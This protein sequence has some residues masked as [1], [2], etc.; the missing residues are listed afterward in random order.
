MLQ[1]NFLPESMY[2]IDSSMTYEKLCRFYNE[3]TTLTGKVRR[4]NS[5]KKI[6]EVELGNGF[7]GFM[8][9]EEATIYSLYKPDGTI[10]PNLNNLVEKTI[11]VRI[12]SLDSSTQ[13][14]FLS[15]KAHMLDAINVFKNETTIINAYIISFSKHSA[16]FDIGAGIIGRANTKNFSTTIFRNIRDIGFKVG[17]IVTVQILSFLEDC[18]K[19]DVS[20]V[21]PLPSV[22][23]ALSEGDV[24]TAKVF[25]P[26]NDVEKIGYYVLV[27]KNYKG[28]VDSP[29]LNLKYGDI[30][31]V[32]IKKIKEDGNL[33]VTLIKN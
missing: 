25:E 28:I 16:F 4:I 9:F 20:R 5:S 1:Q 29:Y 19:F 27:E 2:K 13:T 10:S 17:D 3:G 31:T 7:L 32:F 18:A 21:N 30:I 33:K 23:N 26:V 24:V 8:S 22:F 12:I 11:R 14:T 15:R 6:I